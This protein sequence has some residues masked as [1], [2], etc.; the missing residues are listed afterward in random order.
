MTYT[1]YDAID[2]RLFKILAQAYEEGYAAGV[3]DA[4]VGDRTQPNPF[5]SP[6]EQLRQM[7]EQ[8]LEF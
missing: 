8:P 5:L 1:D 6:A 2:Q 4:P 3:A 7:G